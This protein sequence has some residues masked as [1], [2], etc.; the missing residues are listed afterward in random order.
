MIKIYG[1]P[2]S[3]FVRKVILVLEI[4]DIPYEMANVDLHNPTQQF[5]KIS[6]LIKMPALEDGDFYI[7]DSSVICDYLESQY[8]GEPIYPVDPKLRAK[9][10][11]FEEYADTAIFDGTR[12]LYY[13][14]VLKPWLYNDFSVDMEKIDLVLKDT[15]PKVATY[16][17]LHLN[18]KNGKYLVDNFLTLAD[19][20][21]VSQFVNMYHAGYKIHEA[22]YPQLAYYLNFHFRTPLISK[23]IAEDIQILNLNYSLEDYQKIY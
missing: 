16:L 17:E 21:V 10:L 22:Q 7:S 9:T 8:G 18:E 5:A 12:Q 1:A 4:K 3:T 13:Q 23:L 14:K 11:W 20:S 2:N 19:I 15:L 6:P